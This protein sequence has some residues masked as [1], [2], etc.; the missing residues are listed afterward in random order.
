MK[1][2]LFDLEVERP[3]FSILA[4]LWLQL[5]IIG[6]WYVEAVCVLF[7]NPDFITKLPRFKFWFQSFPAI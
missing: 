6:L 1:K 5:P 7:R 2:T 4:F 3:V